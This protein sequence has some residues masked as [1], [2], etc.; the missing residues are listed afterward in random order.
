M[1]PKLK[2]LN[3]EFERKSKRSNEL[4]VKV[5]AGTLTTEEET[6]VNTLD[7][8]LDALAVDI[9]SQQKLV[10]IANKAASRA[11]FQNDAV[12]NAA[13]RDGDENPSGRR[14]SIIP[15]S[16]RRIKVTSFRRTEDSEFSPMEKAYRFGKFLH[17]TLGKSANAQK[18]CAD[19]GI[20]I[21]FHTEG[22]DSA[23]GFLVPEEFDTDMIDLREKYG[24]FRKY[25]KDVNMRSDTKSRPRRTG[26]LVAYFEDEGDLGTDST[27][28]WDRVSLT[29]KKIMVLAKYSSE[30]DEDSLIDI[31]NDLAKEIA[32]AFAVKEDDC[33]FN[34]DGSQPYGGIIGVMAKMLAANSLGIVVG[35]ANNW[36]GLLL[37]D[38]NAVVGA[39][40]E[41][42]DT[43][44][45]AWYCHKTFYHNVMER[46]MLAS[47]GVTAA[48]IAAGRRQP[49]FMGYPVRICQKMPNTSASGQIPVFFGDLA[50]GVD[51]GDRRSTTIAMSEHANFASDQLMI[52]GT[53]RFDINVH[54]VGT[55]ALVGPIVALRL[56]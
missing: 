52:R 42:A 45:A 12:S 28:G 26:G 27:K 46:L 17:A 20:S 53:E 54:D 24:L 33:G 39:L 23:G 50:M 11:S 25:A 1:N 36:G 35:S 44:N 40:P 4:L 38:F 55:S 9:K 13:P 10:E 6:E 14:K 31:G 56:Q 47:G 18:W 21:K 8:E 37:K 15:A 3:E 7:A 30:L 2:A 41:Y 51:F 48:E 34:G 19:N 32:Y 5:A 16:C 43:E 29:A 49:V 22:N